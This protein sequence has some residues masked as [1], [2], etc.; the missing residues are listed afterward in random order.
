MK[1]NMLSEEVVRREVDSYLRQ[2]GAV[3]RGGVKSGEL[4]AHLKDRR[5]KEDNE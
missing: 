5:L 4:P 3:T 2:Y 1:I